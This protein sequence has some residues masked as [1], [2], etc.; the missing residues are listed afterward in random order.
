M[1]AFDL[2]SPP[3][4]ATRKDRLFRRIAD[5][6][7]SWITSGAFEPGQRLPSERELANHLGVSRPSVRQGLILLEVEG[8]VEVRNGAGTFVTHA[9]ALEPHAPFDVD[10]HSLEV[11][12]ARRLV[13]GEVAAMAARARTRL[14]VAAI[15]HAL[16]PLEDLA[17]E[18]G[19]GDA[20]DRWFHLTVAA[21]TRS[22]A[23]GA[24]VGDLC[25]PPRQAADER[26]TVRHWAGALRAAKVID[27]RALA[28]AIEQRDARGARVAMH[29][30]LD[31]RIWVATLTQPA[32]EVGRERRARRIL[33]A[34]EEVTGTRRSALTPG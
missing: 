13:E 31:R 17:R 28:D 20:W 6:L 24:I 3:Q 16:V 29:R 32:K 8:K 18:A 4:P 9:E 7:A 26:R 34:E 1:N 2:V 19:F 14:D 27:H 10:H 25:G 33:R 15:R 23:M 21:A 5:E 22:D 30:V 11:L 12:R